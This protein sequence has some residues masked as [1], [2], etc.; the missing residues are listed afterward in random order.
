MQYIAFRCFC[1]YGLVPWT[2]DSLDPL[3]PGPFLIRRDPRFTFWQG[4]I[5]AFF[6]SWQSYSVLA[7]PGHTVM[8]SSGQ[9]VMADAARVGCDSTAT[10]FSVRYHNEKL[11][12]VNLIGIVKSQSILMVSDQFESK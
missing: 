7:C 5:C 8:P 2:A 9:P 11:K 6:L 1:T 4:S 10:L 3:S 12:S